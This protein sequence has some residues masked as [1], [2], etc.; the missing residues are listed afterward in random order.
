VSRPSAGYSPVDLRTDAAALGLVVTRMPTPLGIA[1]A[2]HRPTPTSRTA[3]IFLHGAAGAWTTWTPLLEAAASSGV[4]IENP[5]LVDM[6]GWGDASSEPTGDDVSI[7]TVCAVVR[8]VALALGFDRWHIVGHSMGGFIAMHMAAI[9]PGSVASVAMVSGTT[10]SV[11]ES[12][13]KPVRNAGVLPGFTGV[14][15]AMRLLAV[16]GGGRGF[17]RVLDRVG[18]LRVLISPLFRHPFAV[19]ASLVS[20]F[21][22]EAR[23]TSF[24]AATRIARAYDAD[25]SWSRITC[26][27]HA[28]QGDRDVFCRSSDLTRLSALH[29]RAVIATLDDCGHFGTAERPAELLAA[30]GLTSG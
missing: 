9:W 1:V 24:L 2:R 17:L 30:L 16:F 3:T 28:V 5:V 15:V 26:P 8:D 29:P 18:L 20:A 7:E 21:A 14:W 10:W 4:S 11:I 13:T 22:V 23:P 27:I 12:L 19:S 6:P 25:G